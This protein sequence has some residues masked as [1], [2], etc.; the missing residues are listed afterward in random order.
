[1]NTE[2]ATRDLRRLIAQVPVT[3][4]HSAREVTGT[5]T[6]LDAKALAAAAGLQAAYKFSVYTVAAD[7]VVQ[8]GDTTTDKTPGNES[9]VTVDGAEFRVLGTSLDSMGVGLRLDLGTKYQ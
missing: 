2:F 6:R 7:W 3:V 9:V 5:K 8:E 1:M 4:T